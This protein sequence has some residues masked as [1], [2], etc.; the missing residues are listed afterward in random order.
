MLFLSVLNPVQYMAISWYYSA[1]ISAFFSMLLLYLAVGETKIKKQKIIKGIWIGVLTAIGYSLRPT[2]AITTI[3]ILFVGMIQRIGKKDKILPYIGSMCIVVVSAFICTFGIELVSYTYISEQKDTYPITHWISMGM[4]GDGTH[5]SYGADYPKDIQTKEDRILYDKNRIKENVSQYNLSTFVNHLAKK[6]YINWCDGSSALNVKLKSDI[7]FSKLY[8]GVVSQRA[9]GWLIYC[10]VFRG[11]TY[12]LIL[13]SLLKNW[14]NKIEKHDV[15]YLNIFGAILFYLIWEV[16]SDYSIPFLTLFLCVAS[17][18]MNWCCNIFKYVEKKKSGKVLATY[19]K[20]IAFTC[21]ALLVVISIFLLK[22]QYKNYVE[23]TYYFTEDCI[24]MNGIKP[25]EKF[26]EI[27]KGN[28]K[29]TQY[30]K[31]DKEFNSLKFFCKKKGGKGT[32]T[33]RLYDVTGKKKEKY[34]Q[35]AMQSESMKAN[36]PYI[37][38][39]KNISKEQIQRGQEKESLLYDEANETG[40]LLLQCNKALKAGEYMI[41]ICPDN[42]RD[43]IC[44]YYNPYNQYDYY[45][46]EFYKS[47]QKQEGELALSVSNRIKQPYITKSTFYLIEFV[48][49]VLVVGGGICFVKSVFRM[50][51]QKM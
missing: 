41:Q 9:D 6:M 33:I 24:A 12:L 35:L 42:K 25:I 37:Q 16:K 34:L 8:Y 43:S 19:G 27:G 46:G 50:K 29:L 22:K 7:K 31:V 18:G 3:A 45:E 15:L 23:E 14:K 30:F 4:E 17:D 28:E 26:E 2:V 5:S 36:S 13:F 44:W 1:T 48:V 11:M 32:Y 20:K 21:V 47:S 51:E 10:Q 39:W 40:Y 49:V 38:E